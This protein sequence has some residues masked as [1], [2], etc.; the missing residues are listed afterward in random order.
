[1][2]SSSFPANEVD[3]LEALRAC[4]ILDTLPDPRFDVLTRLAA[5]VFDV[6]MAHVTFVDEG[7]QWFKSTVGCVP[8]GSETDRDVAFCAHAL[9]NPRQALVVRDATTDDRFADNPLVVGPPGIRFYAGVPIIGSEGHA[10]GTLCVMDTKPR[11]VSASELEI[12]QDLALA[13]SSALDLHRNSS[14][15]Q[16]SEEHHR[17][18]IELSPQ[19]PWTADP[20]GFNTGVGP[21]WSA[22]TGLA[23]E[24]ALG[25]GWAQAVHPDDVEQAEQ[26]WEYARQSGTPYDTEYRLRTKGG[27]YRWFRAYAAP[28]RGQDGAIMRWYGSA[29]D[30]HERK[31]SQLQVEH[32]A[33]H[34]NL[35]GLPGRERFRER[36]DHEIA[37]SCCGASFALLYLDL[38]NFK[39]VNDTL[40]HARGDALLCEVAERLIECVGESGFVARF[41]GDEFL[42]ILTEIERPADVALTCERI[43]VALGGAVKLEN[44]ALAIGASIGAALCPR[45]GTEADKLLQGADL[46]LYRAKAEGR[47]TYRFFETE[48]D[49]KMRRQH[50]LRVDLRRA[51]DRKEFDLA[52]QPLIGLRSGRV[53]GFEA[54]LRWNHPVRGVV[55]PG[56]FIP[57]AEMTGLILP[58]GRWALE[59]A[60]REATSWPD[61]VRVAVNLSPVQ[62]GQ[63]DLPRA[64]AAALAASGL[65]PER[66]E[67]EITESVPLLDN[68]DN[69]AVLRELREMG[70]RI[71]LDDFGTGYA[72]LGYLQR[73]PFNKIK[74]DR[75]FVSRIGEAEQARTIV[76]TILGMCRTLGIAVTAEGVETRQELDF[77]QTHGC[78]QVQGYLFSRPVAAS[79]VLRLLN[80]LKRPLPLVPATR[81]LNLP[82]FPRIPARPE[83]RNNPARPSRFMAGT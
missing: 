83:S 12:L 14:A 62:F 61:D 42:V 77:L 13:V 35:T 68:E 48:M 20:G 63:R 44:N 27:A 81:A 47:Q 23:R 74:I 43:L 79:D 69:L 60:C 49:E 80:T 73:F 56:E 6:P 32:L 46:A 11:N 45:D 66:L 82:L 24:Q 39:A 2:P 4:H 31:L 50:A 53:E 5:R 7:R 72:S 10:L 57:A 75:S 78:D 65:A 59:Q 55:S 21:R 17:Q 58:I 40:G 34:D 30:I 1:M 29:E 70:V 22:T 38:D 3:R 28:R 16:E 15:L 41:G 71:A 25:R 36:L 26:R 67:L 76:S 51:L 9:L 18:T 52:Y 37:R 8:A 33:Y 54:L 64:V 19:I